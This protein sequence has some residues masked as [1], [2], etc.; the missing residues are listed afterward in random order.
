MITIVIANRLLRSAFVG[1]VEASS[2]LAANSWHEKDNI[3]S[4]YSINENQS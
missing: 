3:I 2:P 4:V 1:N